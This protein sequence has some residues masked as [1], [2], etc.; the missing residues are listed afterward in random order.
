VEGVI[1]ERLSELSKPEFE[2]I[3]R[4]VVE[5]DEWTLV[6]LGGVLGALIGLGQAALVQAL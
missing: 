3:L 6:A 1:R 4:G 5:E 2:R